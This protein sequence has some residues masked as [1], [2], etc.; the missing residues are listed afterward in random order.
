MNCIYLLLT[1]IHMFDGQN[2]R[3][4]MLAYLVYI[5]EHVAT[6]ASAGQTSR[7]Q[8]NKSRSMA[9]VAFRICVLLLCAFASASGYIIYRFAM[10]VC[11]Y[12]CIKIFIYD[13]IMNNFEKCRSVASFTKRWASISPLLLLFAAMIVLHHIALGPWFFALRPPDPKHWHS[14]E[15][16]RMIF[17]DTCGKP[18][19]EPC[20]PAGLGEVHQL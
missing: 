14:Q 19:H 15:T 11:V 8:H 12:N 2:I 20:P 13:S 4:H 3:L 6:H 18:R 17:F 9:G 7:R 5:H 1:K 10:C 16:L